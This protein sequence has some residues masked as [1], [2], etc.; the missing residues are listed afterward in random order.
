[1][2]TAKTCLKFLTGNGIKRKHRKRNYVA[3][4]K[5]AI[6]G[7]ASVYGHFDV[8]A[9]RVLLFKTAGKELNH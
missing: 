8:K 1:M 2:N 7:I 9:E 6:K 3:R 4:G 5:K